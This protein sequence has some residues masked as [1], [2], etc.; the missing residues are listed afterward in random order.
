MYY[1]TYSLG[2]GGHARMI[3]QQTTLAIGT[4]FLLLAVAACRQ[5]DPPKL[6]YPAT[7]KGDVV[8]DYFGTK[9]VDPYRWMESLDSAEVAQWV[10]AQNKV[11]F[12]YLDKL[13]L[14]EHFKQRITELWNDRKASGP[15][16]EG[17]RQF[18]VKTYE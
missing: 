16:L 12:E 4:A 13:P 9:I 17:L 6:S 7:K 1:V 11:T 10:A 5:S 15:V 18:Y 8:D 14:L 2:T 3:A